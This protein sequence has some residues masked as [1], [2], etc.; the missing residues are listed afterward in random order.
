MNSI[1]QLLQTPGRTL[2]DVRSPMEFMSEQ[3]LQSVNIPVDQLELRLDEV[4]QLSKPLIVFCRSGARSALACSILMRDGMNEV[5][6]AGS[7]YD[8]QPEIQ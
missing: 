4:K 5:Y 2:L 8:I 7:I 1:T 6:N 3:I